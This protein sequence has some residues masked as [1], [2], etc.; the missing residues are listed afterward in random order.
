MKTTF[1]IFTVFT[2][3]VVFSIY[4]CFSTVE[5]TPAEIKKEKQDSISTHR[6]KK[7]DLALTQLKELTK[8]QMKDPSSFELLDRTYDKKDTGS[9][10]KL[11]IK[12]TG[13]NSFGA[14]VTNVTFG[15]YDIKA[16]AVMITE[17]R[18]E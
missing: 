14:N 15:T 18:Q 13:K 16:D 17:T 2:A 7:I 1:K 5:P 6:E 9:V 4:G 8:K 11:V 12:Y 3:V 10:V